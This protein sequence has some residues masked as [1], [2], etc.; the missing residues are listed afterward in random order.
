MSKMSF[1]EK[2]D[3][4][5]KM[6]QSS[7]L[8]L[9]VI[10]ILLV[11]G[12]IFSTTNKRTITR[13][14]KIYIGF[15]IFTLISMVIIYHTSLSKIFDYMMNNLFIAIYFPNLAIYLAALIITN[16]IVWISIFHFQTSE[17]IK[18][19]N[20]IIYILMNYLLFLI[21]STINKKQLDIFTQSSVYGNK[22]A[23]ALIELSSIIFIVWII[24]LTLYK[25]ILIYVKKDY[26][27]KVKKVVVKKKIKKLPENY[28]PIATPDW[29][30]GKKPKENTLSM[31]LEE[32]NKLLWNQQQANL[33]IEKE[34]Q[35]EKDLTQKYENLLTLNDYKRILKIL[36]QNK[37][38]VVVK[39]ETIEIQPETTPIVKPIINIPKREKAE[40]FEPLI[41][42]EIEIALPQQPEIIDNQEEDYRE[43]QKQE[44]IR[45]EEERKESLRQEKL[46]LEEERKK[47]EKIEKE[48]LEEERK[49]QEKI[50][51]QRLEKE[52]KELETTERQLTEL[53]KLY[54]GIQ[55]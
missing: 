33:Q 53:E 30:Y 4:L 27:P 42:D 6:S 40:E 17:A 49:Q 38:P 32:T 45:L 37:E 18:K 20:C 28:K 7:Y 29:L 51:K 31:K 5:F 8:Y 24:Y 10:L 1:L 44:I 35:K 47:L 22:Q 15:S 11:L 14:K 21:L 23:T 52:R 2:I 50:E 3:I 9:L 16:I 25:I 26:K 46:R 41:F 48:R 43:Q 39:Q 12:I 13:N 55:L 34:I 19:L 36:K 54:Q